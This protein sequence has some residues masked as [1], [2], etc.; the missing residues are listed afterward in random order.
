MLKYTESCIYEDIL[1]I[2][3]DRYEINEHNLRTILKKYKLM[4][5]LEI[6]NFYKNSPLTQIWDFAELRI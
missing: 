6:H 1:T 4:M 2:S 5:G 3:K